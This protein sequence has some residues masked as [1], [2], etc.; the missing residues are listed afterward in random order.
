[1]ARLQTK[2][3]VKRGR[4]GFTLVELL[5]AI[6]IIGIL[7]TLVTLGVSKAMSYA[8][9]VATKTEMAQIEQALGVAAIEMGR[10]PYI[11]SY[12]VLFQT[13]NE[14]EAAIS[15][16]PAGPVKDY[17]QMSYRTLKQM[18]PNWTSASW[19]K[20]QVLNPEQAYVFFLRGRDGTGFSKGPDP[21]S[22]TATGKKFGPYFEFDLKR[23]E[24]DVAGNVLPYPR[25]RD[26]WDNKLAFLVVYSQ[27]MVGSNPTGAVRIDEPSGTAPSFPRRQFQ[28]TGKYYM[29]KGYQIFSAGKDGEWGTIGY[30]LIPFDGLVKNA[31]G[32][33]SDDQANFSESPLGKPIND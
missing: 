27:M 3:R 17:L 22:S 33:E 10:V 2:T 15:P 8:K 16:L 24:K 11:P 23:L 32:L 1:M 14:Y 9:Q 13:P 19:A 25:Y 21:W 4:G 6:L 12:F 7:V 20:G 5:I 30:N 29:P 26:Y 28:S 31:G 18:F